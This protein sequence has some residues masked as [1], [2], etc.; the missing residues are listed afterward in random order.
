M[1]LSD[2]WLIMKHRGCVLRDNLQKCVQKCGVV[3]ME[4]NMNYMNQFVVICNI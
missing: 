3:H 1:F 2:S 4:I